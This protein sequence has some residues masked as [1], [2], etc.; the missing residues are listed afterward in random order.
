MIKYIL[1]PWGLFFVVLCFS[2]MPGYMT[3]VVIVSFI[4]GI[5]DAKQKNKN[6]R[7][8]LKLDDDAWNF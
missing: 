1:L 8:N 2:M 7:L 3:F 4:G 5:L 6:R